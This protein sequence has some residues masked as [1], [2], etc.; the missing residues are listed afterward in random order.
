MKRSKNYRA[1][2]EKIDADAL[3]GPLEAVRLAK[4]GAKAKYDETVEATAGE[5]L[6]ALVEQ[7]KPH[8][9]GW[10]HLGMVPVALAAAAV[11]AAAPR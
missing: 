7:A 9:R 5:R 8:L 6:E 11:T 3:Y 4:E 10:L 2:A 1:T